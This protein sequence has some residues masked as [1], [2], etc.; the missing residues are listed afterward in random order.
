[1]LVLYFLL[2]LFSPIPQKTVGL[3]SLRSSQVALVVKKPSAKA[4]DVRDEGSLPGLGRSPG[5]GHGNPFQY[6]CLENPWTEEPGELQ[7][8]GSQNSWTG[9]TQLSMHRSLN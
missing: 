2:K 8:L 7:S 6:S 5:E 3:R 4:C 1:M 9:L